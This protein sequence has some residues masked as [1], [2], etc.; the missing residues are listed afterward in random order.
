MIMIIW[1]WINRIMINQCRI[2]NSLI[3][4][5]SLLEW[6]IVRSKDKKILWIN[7]NRERLRL[8]MKNSMN[9]NINRNKNR[10]NNSRCSCNSSNRNCINNSNS[11]WVSSSCHNRLIRE[12][13][14]VLIL[15][16][17][18]LIWFQ[19]I[20][21]FLINWI[22]IILKKWDLFY[23]NRVKSSYNLDHNINYR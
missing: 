11:W 18:R 4:R 23:R 19:F 9:I 16:I 6:L 3:N 1:D 17:K 7:S 5:V 10:L 14:L 20:I 21:I 15:K 2:T 22:N 8:I 13:E 12:L